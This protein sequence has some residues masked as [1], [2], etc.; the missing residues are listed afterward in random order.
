[1]K[2]PKKVTIWP[3]FCFIISGRKALRA[4]K[5]AST[6]TSKVLWTVS[7]MSITGI[8]TQTYCLTSSGFKSRINLPC[9]TP[10]LLIKMVGCPIWCQSEISICQYFSRTLAHFLDNL[11]WDCF[12]FFPLGNITLVVCYVVYSLL[13][14]YLFLWKEIRAYNFLSEWD[15]RLRR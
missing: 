11:L 8:S 14:E 3:V 5:W 9:T 4:Q 13:T 6:F 15:S 1:M 10:A 2:R 12:H 7:I